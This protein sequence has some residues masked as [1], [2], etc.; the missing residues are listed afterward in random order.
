MVPVDR[1]QATQEEKRCALE[2]VLHSATMARSDRLKNVLRFLCEAEMEGRP[3]DLNEYT[4]GVKALGQPHDFSPAGN[5]AVRSRVY[6]LRQRLERYYSTEAPDAAVQIHLAKG[7]YVPRFVRAEGEA[8][9]SK[10][11]A[12]VGAK[13]WLIAGGAFSVGAL[14]MAAFTLP[15]RSAGE[16]K[17]W[18]PEL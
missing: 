17:P 2:E 5:S 9:Q 15:S 18:T 13:I 1:S 16:A 6:E 11:A 3:G 12:P 10:A 14:L 4:I 7:T 8:G